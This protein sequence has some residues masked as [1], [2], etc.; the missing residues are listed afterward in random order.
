MKGIALTYWNMRLWLCATI[1]LMAGAAQAQSATTAS[2]G[3]LLYD[4]HCVACHDA[5]VHW[6]AA[7]VVRNWETLV[8]EVRRW[9]A[10]EK[11]QWTDD[12]IDQVARHLNNMYY[13]YPPGNLAQRE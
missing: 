6:R 10:V 2:R 13:R 12:D 3:Q 1:A 4:T 9:Q 11:L 7:K 8:A 5:Q